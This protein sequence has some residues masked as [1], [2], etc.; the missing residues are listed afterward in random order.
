MHI[1][2]LCKYFSYLFLGTK[3]QKQIP[4]ATSAAI[5]K[6]SYKK[7]KKSQKLRKTLTYYAHQQQ[8]VNIPPTEFIIG[9]RLYG[10]L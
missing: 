7:L 5:Y 4:T 3:L 8:T 9:M 2:Y 1:I 6:K 10:T